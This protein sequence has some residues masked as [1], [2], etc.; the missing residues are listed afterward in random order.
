MPPHRQQPN[1]LLC[2]WDSPGKRSLLNWFLYFLHFVFKVFDHLYYHYSEFFSSCLP[3]SFSFVWTSVFLVCSFICIVFLCILIF[4]LTYCVWSLLFPVFTVEFFLPFGFFP[5][6]VGPVVCVSFIW[7]EICAEFLFVFP[8]MGKA[9]WG[10]N[11]VCWWLSL[12]FCF[13]CLDEAFCIECYWRL[14]DA[15]FCIQVVSFVWVLIIWYSLAL[16][17]W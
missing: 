11:P 7:G 14:G 13:V 12:Y 1:R 5:S 6:K 16:V 15:G 3:I 8:L 17:L 2:P 9:E 10:G 4:F